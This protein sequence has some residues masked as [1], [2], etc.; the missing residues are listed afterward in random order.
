MRGKAAAAF[1]AMGI[2]WALVA[3]SGSDST[4]PIGTNGDSGT[5]TGAADSGPAYTLDNVCDLAPGKICPIRQS[6]CLQTGGY[7]EAGCASHTKN[8]CEKDVAAVKAGT[9]TFHPERIDSCLAKL[10]ALTA[11][12]CYATIDTILAFVKDYH[13]CQIFSGSLPEGAACER[14]AQC[15]PA[16]TPTSIVGCD[17]KTKTCKTTRILAAGDACSFS[18]TNPGFCGAGLY[19]DLDVTKPNPTGNCK[20]ATAIGA[21]CD[22]T[23]QFDLECGLGNYCDKA[24]GTCV[25]GK[26]ANASCTSDLECQT[27]SCKGADGG[28]TCTAPNPITKPEECKG[29]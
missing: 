3:C 2:V 22:T 6:C 8:E 17:D 25:K 10:Q 13:D 19:C 24:S 5:D 15:T 26:P 1:A 7:D 29:P 23:K 21:K 27:V 9:E 28:M 18:D 14:D 20:T 12:S 4:S 16:G 11:S